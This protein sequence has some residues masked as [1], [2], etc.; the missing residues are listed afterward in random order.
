M[1]T[2]EVARDRATEITRLIMD[3]NVEAEVVAKRFGVTPSRIYQ[4]LG[5]TTQREQTLM[6][7]LEHKDERYTSKEIAQAVGVDIK[8]VEFQVDRLH[9]RGR[10]K[11]T[12]KQAVGE[13]GDHKMWIDIQLTTAGIAEARTLLPK[14]PEV[15]KEPVYDKPV[16]PDPG[17][18]PVVLTRPGI[19]G[20]EKLDLR[21]HTL[22]A[23]DIPRFPGINKVMERSEKV[24]K[25]TAAAKLLEEAGE[26]DMALGVM[27]KT[28]FEPLELEII[29]FVERYGK[30]WK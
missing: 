30:D 13:A 18:R 10:L 19:D 15:E 22:A 9:K 4:I 11:A 20:A 8:K 23:S 26:D 21:A 5:K 2:A 12:H 1:I 24:A 16:Q 27:A 6:F 7:L 14:K 28:E 29:H 25:L 3:E 17:S